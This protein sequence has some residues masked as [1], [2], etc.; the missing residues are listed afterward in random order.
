VVF[1]RERTPSL[2]KLFR[3]LEPSLG[4]DRLRQ[5]QQARRVKPLSSNGF[6]EGGGLSRLA[7]RLG[8]IAREPVGQ[9]DGQSPAGRVRRIANLRER[10]P[11]A[12]RGLRRFF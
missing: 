2:G 3:L 7:L 11:R 10:V 6:E 5:I 9:E 4:R 1:P 12:I 8:P